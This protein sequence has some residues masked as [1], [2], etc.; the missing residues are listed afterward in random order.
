MDGQRVAKAEQEH[1]QAPQLPPEAPIS[2]EV[3]DIGGEPFCLWT[4]GEG[5][6]GTLLWLHATGF[7]SLCYSQMLARLAGVLQGWRVLALDQRGHGETRAAADPAGLDSWQPYIDTV[8]QLLPSL[9]QPVF[10]AGH[11]MGGTV[12]IE[13]AAHAPELVQMLGLVDPVLI[14]RPRLW[15][16]LLFPGQ[17][18][19]RNRMIERARTRRNSFASRQEALQSYLGRG[20]FATWPQPAVA[21]YVQ[22]GTRAADGEENSKDPSALCL[23]CDP[24]WEARTFL[25]SPGQNPWG[26]LQQVRCPTVIAV[27]SQDST[28]SPFYRAKMAKWKQQPPLFV[29]QATHSLPMELPGDMALLLG[30]MALWPPKPET[31]GQNEGAC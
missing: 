31:A 12:S 13:A 11:S 26:A 7:H 5:N 21:A 19:H 9:R 16:R 8:L 20:I 3:L 4:F 23:S 17:I 15:H 18:R 29:Y 25:A 14:H 30:G 6:K 1:P 27:A 28:F 2:R 24:E 22:G 10:L